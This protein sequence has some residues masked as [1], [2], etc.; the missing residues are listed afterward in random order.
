MIAWLQRFLWEETY[1]SQV[2][3]SVIGL[4]GVLFLTDT[5]TL[6]SLGERFGQVGWWIGMFLT[7]CAWWIRSGDATLQ[8]L[9]KTPD[10]VLHE[11]GVATTSKGNGRL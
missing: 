7:G 10:D 8:T 9:K 4:L 11:I 6:E 3:R 5:I 1:F 2:I